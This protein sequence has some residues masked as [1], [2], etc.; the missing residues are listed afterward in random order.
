MAQAVDP[1]YE[2]RL[3]AAAAKEVIRAE[4]HRPIDASAGGDRSAASALRKSQEARRENFQ[5]VLTRPFDKAFEI[6][7]NGEYVVFHVGRQHVEVGQDLIIDFRAPM[8]REEHTS[9]VTELRVMQYKEDEIHEVLVKGERRGRGLKSLDLSSGSPSSPPSREG[10]SAKSLD[11]RRKQQR[12]TRSKGKKQ[13]MDEETQVLGSGGFVDAVLSSMV[14]RRGGKMNDIVATIQ[15]DQDELMRLPTGTSLAIEGGPGT[16]KTVVGL[17]RLAF[18]A[19]E[20]RERRASRTL[21]MVGPTDQFV[22]YVKDVLFSLGER[23]VRQISFSGLCASELSAGEVRDIKVTLV[24]SDTTAL[25][26][27]TVAIFRSLRRMLLGRI[28]SVYLEIRSAKTVWISPVQI[29]EFLSAR[30]VAFL[31][32]PAS[33]KSLRQDL[34]DWIFAYSSDARNFGELE[35]REKQSRQVGDEVESRRKS[36]EEPDVI[37][38]DLRKRGTTLR[39]E[40]TRIA[41]RVVP[42]DEP[43][44]MLA[45]FHD[46]KVSVFPTSDSPFAA[47][48]DEIFIRQ[49]VARAETSSSVAERR[50]GAIAADDF[51]LIHELGVAIRGLSPQTYGHVMIDE[52][53]DVTPAMAHVLRRYFSSGQVTLLGDFNQRVR[54][55]AVRSWSELGLWLGLEYL[56]VKSLKKSYRV[57]KQTLDLAARVLVPADRARA[58]EG[59]RSGESPIFHRVSQSRFADAVTKLVNKSQEGQILV[60]ADR[61]FGHSFESD[62]ERVTLVEPRDA[63][64]LEA[65][66]VIVVEP[67]LWVVESDE[68]RHQLYVALTR[69]MSRLAVVHSEDLPFGLGKPTRGSSGRSGSKVARTVRRTWW[70]KRR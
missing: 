18:V 26:K 37:S 41:E 33:M 22:R 38:V 6:P 35:A 24:S 19:Y 69:T 2:E 65:G 42:D 68:S 52:A 32:G 29:E 7:H 44:S 12:K 43:V 4:V 47:T 40:A 57:P 55:D 58:P 8:A 15:A 9:A 61:D 46:S 63:N 62:D 21:L 70:G 30:T 20:D 16:G 11:P 64:G 66:L 17:H 49:V 54:P 39:A 23:E 5:E 25:A 56:E 36:G 59:V 3:F 67:A 53:Q 45:R 31:N 14:S 34:S 13:V 10:E 28:R 51:P 48:D 1:E 60:I 27:S 50:S